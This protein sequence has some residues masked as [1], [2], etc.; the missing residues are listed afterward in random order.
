MQ[1]QKREI[2]L[3]RSF[4]FIV[5]IAA[6]GFGLYALR[7]V[8]TP[9]FLAFTIAYIF[10]PVVARLERWGVPRGLGIA[11]V[12]LSFTSAITAF[13][14]LVIPEVA[15][16]V[17]SVARELP[18]HA[19][20]ALS[21]LEPILKQ[22]GIA[23]PH[24]A[25]EWID[26]LKSRADSLS[27]G[28]LAPVGNALK[29]LIGGTVSAIGAAVGALIVPILAVYL[30]ADF[31]HMVEG[32]HRLVPLRYRDTVASYATE[33]DSTLSQFMR[34][35][36]T[37][38]VILA[39]LYGGS[40]LALGVRLA[41]PIGIAAG[42]LNFVPYVGGAFALV[43]GILMSLLGG[44]GAGQIAGVVVAYA[45]VQTLEGF[46]ITPRI[47]G[48][49]VG[50]REVWVLLALFVGG[51]V[52]GVL[53]VLLAVPA[54]AVLKI[55]VSRA[56]E[57]Y[58]ESGLFL[59]PATAEGL[60][61]GAAAVAIGAHADR[62]SGR[63]PPADDGGATLTDQTSAVAEHEAPGPDAEPDADDVRDADGAD[64]SAP[65]ETKP[66]AADGED[67]DSVS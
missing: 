8:L 44:G 2:I 16:D 13:L 24:T 17:A 51:E 28:Q 27:P 40:Y 14:L 32:I 39:A 65:S 63:D 67:P 43:A 25:D 19:K 37:V 35:Q 36:L 9:I 3:S 22:Q 55:F 61:P 42:I 21:R 10:Q 6:V 58:Q 1:P 41:I 12:L 64:S 56:I 30:L 47:V 31:D 23:I 49:S 4:Y 52:F 66:D 48:E 57:A 26:Q 46:V 38:M 54:A 15:K 20:N 11:I 53:G 45:V 59:A 18:G 62:V 33:V 7:E 60:A 29:A 5:A 50:L 34:G